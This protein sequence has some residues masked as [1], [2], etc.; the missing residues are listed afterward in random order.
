MTDATSHTVAAAEKDSTNYSVT[1]DEDTFSIPIS[2]NFVSF[3]TSGNSIPSSPSLAL[4][5]F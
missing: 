5:S 1:V 3:S 4:V 2:I